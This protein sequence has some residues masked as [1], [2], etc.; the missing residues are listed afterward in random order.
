MSGRVSNNSTMKQGHLIKTAIAVGIFLAI[1][2][3]AFGVTAFDPSQVS[4]SINT[5]TG[6]VRLSYPGTPTYDA[7]ND[8]YTVPAVIGE[9]VSAPDPARAAQGDATSKPVIVGNQVGMT[10]PGADMLNLANGAWVNSI[11]SASPSP[12]LTQ[13][14]DSIA[15][16]Q[17]TSNDIKVGDIFSL[18][19]DQSC[20]QIT[21]LDTGEQDMC[22][23][24][25]ADVKAAMFP[26]SNPLGSSVGGNFIANNAGNVLTSCVQTTPS[27]CVHIKW[28]VVFSA[29]SSCPSN[30]D[31]SKPPAPPTS[32]ELAAAI[33]TALDNWSSNGLA[34]DFKNAA[35]N[36]SPSID[37]VGP[38]SDD[39]DNWKL[40]NQNNANNTIS[41]GLGSGIGP[42][43][44]RPCGDPGG[45]GW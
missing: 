30:F 24:T 26:D 28:T 36:G 44:K 18:D 45:Q 16:V 25:C 7:Q 19:G 42:D 34:E 40:Q 38:T 3:E 21:A 17:Q 22:F 43:E 32:D 10:L 31:I 41:S 15:N 4:Q 11:P 29:P 5:A 6:Q 39:I 9:E 1:S 27:H 8:T 37:G 33:T 12:T 23:M 14:I 20:R 35:E 13:A 2:V